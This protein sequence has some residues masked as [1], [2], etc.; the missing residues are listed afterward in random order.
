MLDVAQRLL[1]LDVNGQSEVARQELAL[2]NAQLTM[3]VRDIQHAGVEV[4]ICG[5]VSQPLEAALL[6][7]G[8]RV[9]S[10]ICGPIEDVWR[11]FLTDGLAD[12]TYIMPGCCGQGRRRHG[13]C[14]GGRRFMER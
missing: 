8:I 6:A 2:T 3:R 4:L 12:A 14:G 11:A 13:R 5:A 1:V 9:M 10:R 7:A